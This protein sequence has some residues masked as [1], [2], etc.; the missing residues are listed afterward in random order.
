LLGGTGEEIR[1]AADLGD[2]FA[3]ARMARKTGEDSFQLAEKS[4]AQGEREGCTN[5]DV[6]TE[7]EQDARK[8]W[9]EQKRTF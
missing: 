3:Q 5:L 8:W 7:V 1:R 2:A 4:A 9:K 6:A